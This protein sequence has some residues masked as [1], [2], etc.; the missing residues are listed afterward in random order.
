V[1]TLL[2]MMW[3]VALG[4]TAL[5]Q[6]VMRDGGIIDPEDGV[7]TD[8]ALF[9]MLDL[10]PGSAVLSGLALLMIVVFF[11]TSS[12][13]GSFVVDM[14]STGG[15]PNPP[16]WSRTFWAILEGAIAAAL[17]IAGTASGNPQGGLAALQT[18]AILVAAPFTI[19]MILACF[20]LV[21]SLREEHYEKLRL[22]RSLLRREV[23]QEA[24]EALSSGKYD[25]VG[26]GS[27]ESKP[28]SSS[29]R[30][31]GRRSKS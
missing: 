17:I 21:R 15:S 27:T 3:F 29:T 19:V 2:T 14:I 30:R 26:S 24:A 20:A 1:P 31:F 6:E 5:Y 11:V 9:Q 12:D 22:E 25:Y 4:G 10:V 7:S 16:M 18:M 28:R 8:T 13:S 23:A